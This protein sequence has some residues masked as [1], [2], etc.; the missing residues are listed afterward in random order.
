MRQYGKL[1]TGYWRN[2]KIRPLSERSRFLMAYLLSCPHGNSVGCFVLPIEYICADMQWDAETVSKLV[3]ELVSKGLIERDE[4]S[5]LTRIKGWWGHN[6][7][8]N[9]NVAKAALKAMR[10]LPRGGVFSNAVKALNEFNNKFVNVLRNEFDDVFRNIEPEPEPEPEPNPAQPLAAAV[11]SAANPE[12]EQTEGVPAVDAPAPAPASPVP[13]PEPPQGSSVAAPWVVLI[14]IFDQERVAVFGQARARPFPAAKDHGVA[15]QLHELV[16]SSGFPP[17][18]VR[19]VFRSVFER[20]KANNDEPAGSLA[21]MRNPIVTA[22]REAATEIPP[23]LAKPKPARPDIRDLLA[24]DRADFERT[25]GPSEP[26]PATPEAA[27]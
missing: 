19:G 20:Q 27:A 8:E 25:F 2:P 9:L 5:C 11:V 14:Q 7:I 24:K 21:Y 13:D 6:S 26:E 4:A 3:S 17:E 23:I 16:T 22:L 10:Q 12:P 18:F 1:E 15:P